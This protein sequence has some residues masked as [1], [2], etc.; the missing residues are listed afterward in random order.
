ME[1]KYALT[2]CPTAHIGAIG[3]AQR[4]QIQIGIGRHYC[5]HLVGFPLTRAIRFSTAVV[6]IGDVAH[7]A[8][9]GHAAHILIEYIDFEIQVGVVQSL[10][11][12][13]NRHS[14]SAAEGVTAKRR[15]R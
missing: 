6:H 10:G 9:A 8:A 11:H 13:Q 4:C 15:M 14:Q 5:W 7:R 1:A 12:A 3:A 2:C